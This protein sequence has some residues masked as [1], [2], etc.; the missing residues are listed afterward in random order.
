V[1]ADNLDEEEQASVANDGS[2]QTVEYWWHTTR[3][4]WL[5]IM[6]QTYK[7]RKCHNKC[8]GNWFIRSEDCIAICDNISKVSTYWGS[9]SSDI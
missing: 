1:D 5:D 6:F 2:T 4:W 8:N 7:I 3:V 9:A